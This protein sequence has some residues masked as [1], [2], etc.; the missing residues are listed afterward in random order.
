M[1]IRPA[2]MEDITV[3]VS[4]VNNAYRGEGG[5]TSES[6]LI[7]GPRTRGAVSCWGPVWDAETAAG[8]GGVGKEVLEVDIAEPEIDDA[9][10]KVLIE[11]ELCREG[12]GIRRLSIL[13][14]EGNRSF[15]QREVLPCRVF[16]MADPFPAAASP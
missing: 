13:V 15:R 11:R 9:V 7:G 12:R 4:L 16:R 14:Q 10:K 6:H 5:W 3:L 1:D 2:K 8:T